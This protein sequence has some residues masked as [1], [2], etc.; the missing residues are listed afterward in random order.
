MDLTRHR[1]EHVLQ[2]LPCRLPVGLVDQLG[3][4][5]LAGPIDADKEVEL[6]FGGLKLCDVDMEEADGVALELLT[7]RLVPFDIRQPGDTMTLQTP[8]QR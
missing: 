6:A 3:D 4:R 5:E 1:I 7:F 8:V 2:E